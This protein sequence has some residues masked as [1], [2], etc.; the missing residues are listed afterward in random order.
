MYILTYIWR[1]VCTRPEKC[2]YRKDD[3][4]ARARSFLTGQTACTDGF[5]WNRSKQEMLRSETPRLPTTKRQTDPR[6]RVTV[7]PPSRPAVLNSNF[8]RRRD[9]DEKYVHTW[10]GTWKRDVKNQTDK[11]NIVIDN[12]KRISF[13]KRVSSRDMKKYT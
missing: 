2:Q 3:S 11:L 10:N 6:T 13:D 12:E 7:R 4:G 1:C 9:C 5:S 8:T